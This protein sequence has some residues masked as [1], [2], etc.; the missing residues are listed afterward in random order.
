V[1]LEHLDLGD[2]LARVADRVLSDGDMPMPEQRD[3]FFQRAG[4]VEHP[5]GPPVANAAGFQIPDVH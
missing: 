1:T 4:G 3:L 5:F 2:P